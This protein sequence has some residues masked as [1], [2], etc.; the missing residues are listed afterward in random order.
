MLKISRNENKLVVNIE[1]GIFGDDN[2]FELEIN[3]QF[4]YQAELLRRQLNDNMNR[5]LKI[6]KEKYY[7][8]GWKDA[9]AKK[10][11]KRNNFWGGWEK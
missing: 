4:N 1:H 3:Q 5:Y 10:G 8:Q 6:M 11:G 7:N 2:I 9:K